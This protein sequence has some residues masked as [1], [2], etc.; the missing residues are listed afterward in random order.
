[1]PARMRPKATEALS[2]LA[3]GPACA[4]REGER[5]GE[6]DRQREIDP[7][8][9]P[10]LRFSRGVETVPLQLFEDLKPAAGVSQ[11]CAPVYVSGGCKCTFELLQDMEQGI[12]V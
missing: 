11:E 12:V 5:E 6:T 7:S 10:G 3:H 4:I 1:M 8:C 9:S 2:C